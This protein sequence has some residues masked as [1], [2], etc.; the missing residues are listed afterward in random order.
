MGNQ[1]VEKLVT[2]IDI[3]CCFG[4][5]KYFVS[6]VE[7]VPSLYT[8]IQEVVKIMIDKTMGDQIIKIIEQIN[9]SSLTTRYNKNYIIII[10][11]CVVFILLVFIYALY[12]VFS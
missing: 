3:G 7:F 12:I 11:S 6:E 1:Y 2:R 8:N 5:P 10:C 9:F 4:I